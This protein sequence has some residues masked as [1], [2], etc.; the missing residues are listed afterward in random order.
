MLITRCAICAVVISFVL[1]GYAADAQT[2]S[3]ELLAATAVLTPE[4]Q[5]EV[6][7]SVTAKVHALIEGENKSIGEIARDLAG[8][9]RQSQSQF[10]KSAYSAEVSNQLSITAMSSDRSIVRLNSMLVASQL[11]RSAVGLI[12]KGMNDKMPGVRYLAGLAI[13]RLGSELARPN[14]GEIVTTLE[15]AIASESSDDVLT[16]LM[17]GLVALD[18]SEARRS[19]LK[20]VNARVDIHAKTPSRSVRPEQTAMDRLQ[21]QLIQAY[22][23][24]QT[25]PIGLMKDLARVTY[26]CLLLS[27]RLLN[28]ERTTETIEPGYWSMIRTS[29]RILRWTIGRLSGGNAP[30]L[31]PPVGDEK[32]AAEVQLIVGEWRDLLTRSP[33][34]L[35]SGDLE[36]QISQS[37]E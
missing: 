31:P 36:V 2:I 37:P 4:Q 1:A 10:F 18:S 32:I 19:L 3:P 27:A 5:A 34:S 6:R 14:P 15:A 9:I 33:T 29:D 28:D 16:Q 11:D 25:V 13:N 23:S 8:P 26:R 22:A 24:D 30:D 17:L 20:T 12:V 21:R 35:R 7:D